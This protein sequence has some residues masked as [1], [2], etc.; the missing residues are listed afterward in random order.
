MPGP[1]KGPEYLRQKAPVPKELNANQDN[2]DIPRRVRPEKIN[3]K[4]RHRTILNFNEFSFEFS[5]F[6][7][8]A[9][10]IQKRV[11]QKRYGGRKRTDVFSP[12]TAAA[13]RAAEDRKFKC[14]T[15]GDWSELMD[16]NV[17]WLSAT[18]FVV[19]LITLCFMD[20]GDS[21]TIAIL[22]IAYPTSSCIGTIE[23]A[24]SEAKYPDR[25]SFFIV[26]AGDSKSCLKG[27]DNLFIG[28]EIIQDHIGSISQSYS[29][30]FGFN[31][32]KALLVDEHIYSKGK[33]FD[34]VLD[35]HAHTLFNTHWDE[36]VLEE[37]S[38]IRNQRAF[39]TTH[40][41]GADMIA[42]HEFHQDDGYLMNIMCRITYKPPFRGSKLP[43]IAYNHPVQ[44]QP[45]LRRKDFQGRSHFV[46]IEVPFWSSYFSFG[47]F[48]YLLEVP[49]DPNLKNLIEEDGPELLFAARL[50]THGFKFYAPT[51]DLAFHSYQQ[52]DREH[53]QT[54]KYYIKQL[55]MDQ[56]R[57]WGFLLNGDGGDSRY[58]F[59]KEM[60]V[61][62]Y[63]RITGVDLRMQKPSSVC[64]AVKSRRWKS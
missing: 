47:P 11:N 4:S 27:Y 56:E 1:N 40:P 61:E 39:L 7:G 29:P 59:G 19:M 26:N 36:R 34:F 28:S 30:D 46:P 63:L 38:S 24:L 43:V 31:A 33:S 64:K 49:Y 12:R 62:E 6:Q 21:R 52:H 37:W 2:R 3:P 16:S 10:S 53:F 25:L 48:E 5:Q 15:Y 57:I 42:K 20:F 17:F 14:P 32:A 54:I 44:I 51:Q 23:T 13:L 60:T 35:T 9:A 41:A 8:Y 58:G 55:G 45:P 18:T 50:R 22:M